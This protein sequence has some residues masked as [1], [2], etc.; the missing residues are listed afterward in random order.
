MLLASQNKIQF[1]LGV[2][3]HQPI[4][5]SERVMEDSYQHSYLPFIDVL[6]R[7]PVVRATI[8]YAGHL[9]HWL[10]ERHPEFVERLCLLVK[11]GQ[12]EILTGAFY[13]PILSIIPDGDKV[14][15]IQKLS[16]TIRRLLATEPTGL[17]LA[18][19]AW[20]P[21]LAQSIAQAGARYALVD[22]AHFIATGLRGGELLGYYQTEEQGHAMSVFPIDHRLRALIPF[23]APEKALEYLRAQATPDG[24]R[25]AI[26]FDDGEKFGGWQNT[27]QTVYVE[28]WLERF[29]SA[30][31]A[32]QDWLT[33]CTIND[34][35]TRYRPWG[36]IYLP[37]CSYQEMQTWALPVEQAL[38]FE[39]AIAT[40]KKPTSN[41]LRG[42][43][44]RHFLVRYPE[45]NSLHKKMLRVAGQ[46]QD[47]KPLCD[48]STY[49]AMQDALW[50][51]Q[52][53]DPYWHGIFGG[54]YLNHL[55]S[56]N[57]TALLQAE[58]LVDQVRDKTD[59][60]LT[61]ELSDFDRDGANEALVSTR[62]QNLYF[63]P[64]YG[65][66]LFEHDDKQ[67]AYNW[68]DTL[69]R[70]PEMYHNQIARQAGGLERLL[71]YDWYRRLSLLDHFLHPD[72]RL[73]T[74][75]NMTF[76]EQGDFINQAYALETKE[77]PLEII[78]ELS[79]DGHV[80]VGSEFWPVRVQK[81]ITIKKA[82]QGFA[83]DYTLTNLWD[84]PLEVWF[85]VEF[86]LNAR[87]AT[88]QES[89]FFS[90]TGRHI[91]QPWLLAVA[92]EESLREISL[93]DDALKAVLE[94]SWSET[95]NLWRFPIETVS[96]SEAGFERIY[97]SSV[98]LPHW[99]LSLEPNGRWECR[100]DL[101][102]SDL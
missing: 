82:G 72:S 74:F 4:G 54:L 27:Y 75:H 83:V 33:S 92:E 94:L 68:L 23:E 21:Q 78:L 42:G 59:D 70:R 58:A 95:G 12:V 46:V 32:N 87:E 98:L 29:F 24:S 93:R 16:A 61:L 90:T 45:A 85:G 19:R 69:A 89:A 18:A 22:D 80:W 50:R 44:W 38:L 28:G 17:W 51:G 25:L 81:S 49:Q 35:R 2:H 97:Q 96:R 53:N 86:N 57:Y 101:K 102:V 20:E 84:R 8:H 15:Q 31:E 60:F 40:T 67:R 39:E 100:I 63:M 73:E 52:S 55:R 10:A 6:E 48:E 66:S 37:T 47:V 41:F 43:Y 9:L 71:H 76:G 99:R 77:T 34:Y 5:N 7:H 36:R 3:N 88:N 1:A 26:A 30:I 56:A 62:A 14:G 79:R 64:G 91:E 11:K 65:G 13:E